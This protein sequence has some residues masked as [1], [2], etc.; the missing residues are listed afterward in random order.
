MLKN[1]YKTKITNENKELVNLIKRGL[2]DLKNKIKK[3]SYVENEFENPD[4]IR[5]LLEMISDFKET[6]Q[7]GEG[8]KTVKPGQVLSDD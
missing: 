7:E 1:L 6:F 2:I 3:M 8:L 4:E 5:N